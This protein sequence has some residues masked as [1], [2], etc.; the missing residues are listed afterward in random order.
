M[1]AF[2]FLPLRFATGVYTSVYTN[3]E[4]ISEEN[5][6]ETLVSVVTGWFKDT[7]SSDFQSPSQDKVQ[8]SFKSTTWGW[9]QASG[10]HHQPARSWLSFKRNFQGYTETCMAV[11]RDRQSLVAWTWQPAVSGTWECSIKGVY[12]VLGCS[13]RKIHY[14]NLSMVFCLRLIVPQLSHHSSLYLLSCLRI[15][16]TQ[17][18]LICSFLVSLWAQS[19]VTHINCRFSQ[20]CIFRSLTD[21]I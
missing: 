4:S 3:T 17:W 20:F 7:L 18:Q 9:V 6:V 1:L 15:W 12:L 2:V 10:N 14:N 8:F 19:Q 5:R 21:Q 13:K 16:I 11:S